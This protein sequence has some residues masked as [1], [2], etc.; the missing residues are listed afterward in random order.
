MKE[1][2]SINSKPVS[3]EEIVK[4]M[5]D[6]ERI[7]RYGCQNHILKEKATKGIS[8]SVCLKEPEP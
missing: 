3:A 4:S 1:K 2:T 5:F 6:L 8:K 7:Y